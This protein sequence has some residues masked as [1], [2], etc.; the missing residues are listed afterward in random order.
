[1]NKYVGHIEELL[2]LYDCVIIPG[3]GGFVGVYADA[4]IDEKRGAIRPPRKT[5]V[6]NRHLQQ[7]DGLLIDWIARKEAIPY[8]K[9]ERRVALFREELRVRLNQRQQITFGRVGTFAM[10]RRLNI[11]FTPSG[12]NFLADTMGMDTLAVA[13]PRR[14]TAAELINTD[15]PNLL[16]RLLKYGTSAAI[17]AGI[18]VIS[19]QDIFRGDSH[20]AT[21]GMQPTASASSP[22]ADRPAPSVSPACDFVD[23]DPLAADF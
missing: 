1:M 22:S 8:E 15:G 19:Q 21:A 2:Y 12:H 13:A 14:Q 9:A 11:S 4:A 5:V 10:D 6:F 20:T 23:F 17:I 3:F 18:V 16:T 7:N